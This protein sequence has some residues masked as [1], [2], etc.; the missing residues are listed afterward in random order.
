M[1]AHLW[2]HTERH[3]HTKEVQ[4]KSKVKPYLVWNARCQE[5]DSVQQ[6]LGSFM[7]WIMYPGKMHSSPGTLW[8]WPF[9]GSWIFADVITL[10]W[11]HS[12][13]GLREK[14]LSRVAYIDCRLHVSPIDCSLPCFYVHGIFQ[15]KVLEWVA[16]LFSSAWSKF[17]CPYRRGTFA[18]RDSERHRQ[19]DALWR[20]KMEAEMGVLLP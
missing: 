7:G 3:T 6:W 8:I 2:T 15:A 16:I 10:R 14:L 13:W 12:E 9:W 19:E 18:H 5:R 11:G 20:W 17:Q 4:D 1:H